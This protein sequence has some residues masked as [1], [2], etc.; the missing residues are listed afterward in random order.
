MLQHFNRQYPFIQIG[1]FNLPEIDW[2]LGWAGTKGGKMMLDVM[3]DKFW[4]QHVRVSTHVAGNILDLALSSS[5]DLIAGVSAEGFLG[6]SDH[7]CLELDLVG[8]KQSETYEEVPDWGKANFE[9]IKVA[10]QEVD[11]DTEFSNMSGEDCLTL[12]QNI[13]DREVEKAVPKKRR[14]QNFKPVWMN[15]SLMR[16]IRK[17]R[18]AWKFY[19]TDP[20]CAKDFKSFQDYRKIQKEVKNAVKQAKRKLERNLLSSTRKIPRLSILI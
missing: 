4:L 16:L 13:L 14:R 3:D 20:R 12:F 5:H 10:M 2:E 8:P 1:D 17:K 19:S 6:T 18:R 9:A 11:W 15:K 7:V